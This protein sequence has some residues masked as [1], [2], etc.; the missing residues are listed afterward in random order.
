MNEEYT[1]KN[2]DDDECTLNPQDKDY[3]ILISRL[4]EISSNITQL[5]KTIFS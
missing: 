1:S 3:T 2:I 5:E 4:K